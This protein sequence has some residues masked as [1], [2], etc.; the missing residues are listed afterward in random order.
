MLARGN[1]MVIK[2]VGI[3]ERRKK[4]RR[5]LC[6]RNQRANCL[7]LFILFCIFFFLQ[8]KLQQNITMNILLIIIIKTYVRI[9]MYKHL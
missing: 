3:P 1:K 5:R 6:G 7:H 9:R 2:D 8:N 4:N